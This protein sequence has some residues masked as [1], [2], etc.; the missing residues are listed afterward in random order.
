MNDEHLAR[1]ALQI[2]FEVGREDIG[3]LVAEHGPVR[4]VNALESGGLTGSSIEGLR[5]RWRGCAALERAATELRR[6]TSEGVSVLMPGDVQWPSALEDLDFRAPLLLRTVGDVG[7][8]GHAS[9]RVA[10]VGA[11]AATRYGTWVAE[12]L[13]TGLSDANVTVV[14]GGA[15]GIDA[16]AHRGALCGAGRATILV[17]AAGIEFP[18]PSSHVQLFNDVRQ[19]GLLVSEVPMGTHASRHRFLIR[20]RMVAAMSAATVVVEA[21]R[22]SGALAT[23]REAAALGRLLLAVP[24]PVTSTMS[25]GTHELIR[26]GDAELAANADDVLASVNLRGH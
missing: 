2:A 7:L 24:G 26:S 25:E 4:L 17:T 23:A 14:S 12:E 22:R 10:V 21:A 19:H 9:P 11:R 15:F 18:V 13:S 1:A 6:C 16:A 5:Q 3:M 20:N 8:L